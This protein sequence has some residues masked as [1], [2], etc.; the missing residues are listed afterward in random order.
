[1][2]HH[3]TSERAKRARK[4]KLLFLGYQTG[5]V[6]IGLAVWGVTGSGLAGIFTP[7]GLMFIA[8]SVFQL[9]RPSLERRIAAKEATRRGSTPE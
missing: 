9:I 1:M 5:L 2:E 8:P 6:L 4:I 7:V 3:T